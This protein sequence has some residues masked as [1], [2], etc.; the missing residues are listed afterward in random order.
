[1]WLFRTKKPR[2]QEPAGGSATIQVLSARQQG[3]GSVAIIDLRT[4]EGVAGNVPPEDIVGAFAVASGRLGEYHTNPNYRAFTEHGLT[5]LPPNL[6]ALH[7]RELM[8]LK[9]DPSAIGESR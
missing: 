1:M 3:R 8:R 7:I 5:R 4:P 9:V 6:H 2:E